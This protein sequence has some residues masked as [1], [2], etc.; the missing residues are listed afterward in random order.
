[1]ATGNSRVIVGQEVKGKWGE[2]GASPKGYVLRRTNFKVDPSRPEL[3][4]GEMRADPF[5]A[6]S[7]M[8]ATEIKGEFGFEVVPGAHDVIM[9]GILHNEWEGNVLKAG[10]DFTPRSLFLEHH[11]LGRHILYTGVVLEKVGLTFEP[12][13]MVKASASFLAKER[14]ENAAKSVAATIVEAPETLASASWDGV[15]KVDGEASKIMTALTIDITRTVNMRA[16]LGEKYPQ[17]AHLSKFDVTG[18]M[19]IRPQGPEWWSRFHN[20]ESRMWL[21]VTISGIAED[22]RPS[23]T[24]SLPRLLLTSAPEDLSDAEDLLI[25]LPFAADV[26]TD[27]DVMVPLFIT[28]SHTEDQ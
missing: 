19:T 11:T 4:S 15:F 24:F 23:Y 12:N 22:E 5:R 7:R 26:D 28:R 6:P 27:P 1:M 2:V 21:E 16:V 9:T 3:T 17:T 20:E 13:G 8:G 10:A 25:D 14:K 18:S